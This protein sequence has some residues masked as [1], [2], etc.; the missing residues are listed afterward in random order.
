MFSAAYKVIVCLLL[1]VTAVL[2]PLLNAFVC[3]T[4][5]K[6]RKFR[7]TGNILICNLALSDGLIGLTLAPLELVYVSHFPRWQLGRSGTDILNSIW[8]FSLVSPFVI[9]S[10]ITIERYRTI[11]T[12]T[13]ATREQISTKKLL[14]VLTFLWL[15]SVVAV[16]FMAGNFTEAQR[17]VY[18]WNVNARFY[19]P[20]LALHIVIPLSIVVAAYY[21]IFKLTKRMHI[22]ELAQSATTNIQS[23]EVRLAKTLAIVIGLLFL[24][25][26][27]VLVIECFY[28]TESTSCITE[29]VGPISV[30]L[31][32][33]SGVMNPIVYFYR[34]PSLR[35]A[36]QHVVG[37]HKEHLPSQMTTRLLPTSGEHSN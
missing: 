22:D 25:W 8:L 7:T 33:F 14:I 32:V 30:W 1:G 3:L 23:R 21:K 15:Y 27:P 28:A 36:F 24:V 13:L 6:Q 34:N 4:I 18:N 5:F 26:L 11:K 31:T 9:V 37:F 2:S 35:A 29:A 19:Y 20:F 10:A 12:F 17:H 16:A